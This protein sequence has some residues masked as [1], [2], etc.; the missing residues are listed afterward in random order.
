MEYDSASRES[1]YLM[2]RKLCPFDKS[3]C[4]GVTC[5]LFSEKNEI[6][7]LLLMCSP[8]NP[9]VTTGSTA[10]SRATDQDNRERKTRF[11]AELFD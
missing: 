1:D 6:C 2:K 11:K 10:E 9:P 4:I 3:E 7:G 5:T 8:G